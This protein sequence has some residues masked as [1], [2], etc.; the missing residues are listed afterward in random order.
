MPDPERPN[1]PNWQGQYNRRLI[2]VFG[3]STVEGFAKRTIEPDDT[4]VRLRGMFADELRKSPFCVPEAKA[5]LADLW[6]HSVSC[7]EQ[8]RAW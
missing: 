3:A 4:P 5:A 2:N 1:D 8:M 7:L 6:A